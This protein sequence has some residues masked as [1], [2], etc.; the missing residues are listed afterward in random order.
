[1][2]FVE[3]LESHD[4]YQSIIQAFEFHSPHKLINDENGLY[5][6]LLQV[7]YVTSSS[8]RNA[9]LFLR[10]EEVEI[11]TCSGDV[12]MELVQL[13]HGLFTKSGLIDFASGLTVMEGYIEPIYPD[14][15]CFEE[16]RGTVTEAGN[17]ED[18]NSISS[19][20]DEHG[21]VKEEGDCTDMNKSHFEKDKI[22][23]SKK[24]FYINHL[25]VASCIITFSATILLFQKGSLTSSSQDVFKLKQN[26]HYVA[27]SLLR[28][29][30]QY[31]NE[32]WE[33]K[34]RFNRMIQLTDKLD[35]L[36]NIN[37]GWHV[38]ESL[39]SIMR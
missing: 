11:I 23:M 25:H 24:A 14:L 39:N 16:Q 32:N 17:Y 28:T 38:F 37:L 36:K 12:I 20:E 21:I 7:S 27:M 8:M 4:E 35:G 19:F 1:M 13:F 2:E 22:K 33:N 3:V 9:Q 30:I 34:L 18:V 10:D 6:P 26:V 5:E 15:P 31:L 29:V